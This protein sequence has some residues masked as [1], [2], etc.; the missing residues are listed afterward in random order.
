VK[1]SWWDL[2]KA[3]AVAI[4]MSMGTGA[5]L[6]YS[7]G[8]PD[9]SKTKAEIR[10]DEDAGYFGDKGY[11]KLETAAVGPLAE[12]LQKTTPFKHVV[13]KDKWIDQPMHFAKLLLEDAILTIV[14]AVTFFFVNKTDEGADAKEVDKNKDGWVS[15][16]EAAEFKTRNPDKRLDRDVEVE[17]V[18]HH[19][20][21]RKGVTVPSSG[22]TDKV[23]TD[24]Q[25]AKET[26]VQL[27]P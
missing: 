10:A 21:P 14:S 20:S 8:K 26:P 5:V 6:G 17:E 2:I 24:R 23:N 1:K 25:A 9:P 15:K 16:E 4:A 19:K 12:T 18:I 11:G 7:K 27:A 13:G 3:R 22:Y